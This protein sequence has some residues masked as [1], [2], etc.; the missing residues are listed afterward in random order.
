M[1]AVFLATNQAAPGAAGYGL[2]AWPC[3]WP[4]CWSTKWDTLCRGQGWAAVPTQIV[5]GPLGGLGTLDVP[6][7]PQAELI[8]VLAGP[9]VNLALLLVTLACAFRR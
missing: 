9:M 6:R 7:E 8:T 1:F 2:L 4:A 3:C 5:I